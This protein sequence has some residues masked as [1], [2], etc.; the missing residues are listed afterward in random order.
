V[1]NETC[2]TAAIVAKLL[3]SA[4][5]LHLFVDFAQFP[6]FAGVADLPRSHECKLKVKIQPSEQPDVSIYNL[7]I[8]S[9]VS[10]VGTLVSFSVHL[11]TGLADVTVS[12]TLS[13]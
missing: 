5:L 3:S 13:L 6:T 9:A 10:P 2:S 11:A 8:Q 12:W 7:S 4:K 1:E